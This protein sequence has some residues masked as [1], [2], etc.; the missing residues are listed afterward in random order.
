MAIEP[1]LEALW[2]KMFSMAVSQLVPN[3]PK[4]KAK[5]RE[6]LAVASVSQA[7]F[8]LE[9]LARRTS[10][11]NAAENAFQAAVLVFE[12]YKL[13]T[14]SRDWREIYQHESVMQRPDWQL[15]ILWGLIHVEEDQIAVLR[16]VLELRL[17]EDS[18]CRREILLEAILEKGIETSAGDLRLM[19]SM[20][21]KKLW[22]A[23]SEERR[24]ELSQIAS[25]LLNKDVDI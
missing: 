5:E 17:D 6:L 24:T 21:S 9:L 1:E 13:D 4:A 2:A 7:R 14:I 12:A 3:T 11:T 25:R 18:L 23:S 16:E 10:F 8:A 19:A 15:N 20:I 22:S